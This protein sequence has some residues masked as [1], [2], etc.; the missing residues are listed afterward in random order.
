MQENLG[1]IQKT[2]SDFT[3]LNQWVVRDYYR[4]VNSVNAFE[5]RIQALSDEQLAAKTEEFRLRLTRGETLADI[6][7]GSLFFYLVASLFDLINL[8]T[9]DFYGI[10]MN[11]CFRGVRR[12]S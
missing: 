11:E 7:A 5:P 1:R 4:L 8:L 2:L 10:A 9:V 6:Q 12:C 3:S